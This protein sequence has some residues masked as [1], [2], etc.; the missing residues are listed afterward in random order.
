[1]ETIFLKA[2]NSIL[3]PEGDRFPSI[4]MFSINLQK[5]IDYAPKESNDCTFIC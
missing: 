3:V 4:K 1:M 2:K 5:P